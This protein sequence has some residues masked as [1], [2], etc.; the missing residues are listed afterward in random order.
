MQ[1]F[2]KQI[3]RGPSV[4]R[5][6]TDFYFGYRI[7]AHSVRF[8][9]WGNDHCSC[10]C[11]LNNC[12]GAWKTFRAST[13]FLCNCLTWKHNC[14]DHCS[15]YILYPQFIIIWFIHSYSSFISVRFVAYSIPVRMHGLISFYFFLLKIITTCVLKVKAN[16]S[17][18]NIH[19]TK[20]PLVVIIVLSKRCQS[21]MP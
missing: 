7:K 10:G 15:L 17:D 19:F 1:H 6:A 21:C 4:R 3:G 16:I 8:V 14:K 12:N 20:I 9:K 11:N 13:F 2:F 18:C 5:C